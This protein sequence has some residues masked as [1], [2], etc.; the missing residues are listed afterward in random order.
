MQRYDEI[1]KGLFFLWNTVY[2]C[3][4]EQ[5]FECCL[6]VERHLQSTQQQ[7][8]DAEDEYEKAEKLLQE[9]LR[10]TKEQLSAAQRVLL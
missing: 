9:Q 4:S 1:Q 10:E 3:D 2:V 8:K 5:L 7:M 6:Q